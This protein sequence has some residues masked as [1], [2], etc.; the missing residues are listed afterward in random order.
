MNGNVISKI[1]TFYNLQ[2]STK[3]LY[4]FKVITINFLTIIVPNTT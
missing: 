3:L 4:C 2:A 1:D